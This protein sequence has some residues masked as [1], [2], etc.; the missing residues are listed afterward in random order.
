MN[1]KVQDLMTHNVFTVK[2][3]DT[4]GKVKRIFNKHGFNVLPVLD[5]EEK[6]IGVISK[7]DVLKA[8]NE[9]SQIHNHMHHNPVTIQP[10][11]N[12]QEAAHL[13]K[14]NHIHH[15]VV[16]FEKQV[17]GIIS[18]YDLLEVLDKRVYKYTEKKSA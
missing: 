14:K 12:L 11:A 13:M 4:I 15:L 10:Y 8:E 5:K 3:N 2:A 17:V 7:G 16:I 1:I 6:L 9:F 18:T